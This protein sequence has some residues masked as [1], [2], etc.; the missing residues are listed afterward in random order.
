MGLE[1][2]CLERSS[3][4]LGLCALAINFPVEESLG[5]WQ[6]L[7]MA[8]TCTIKKIL[9]RNCYI[10]IWKMNNLK[11]IYCNSMSLLHLTFIPEL[12]CNPTD[13]C[14]SNDWISTEQLIVLKYMLQL[15][16]TTVIL[17]CR[18]KL[19]LLRAITASC[20]G[21]LGGG[22]GTGQG[23]MCLNFGIQYSIL[24]NRVKTLERWENLDMII[25]PNSSSGITPGR[26]K[27]A[28]R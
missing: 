23:F 25:L 1:G 17:V 27:Q 11:N 7:Y 13:S 5:S 8:C 22:R 15:T 18:S 2:G 16:L 12:V 9:Y 20:V 19:I 24:W 6:I 28:Y 10:Y 4:C 21:S 14:Q 3:I 26:I